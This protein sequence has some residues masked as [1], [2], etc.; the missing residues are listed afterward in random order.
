VRDGKPHG[1]EWQDDDLLGQRGVVYAR[2]W[3]GFPVYV[4]STQGTLRGRLK[5]H[6]RG[7]RAELGLC[8]W[9]WAE[10]KQMTIVAHKPDPISILGRDILVYRGL[11]A[12]LIVEFRPIPR[13]SR[14]WFV[15][16][17]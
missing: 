9:A 2:M 14:P 8:Y 12:A 15:G 16:R 10:G 5:T 4:G 3:E 13:K 17:I 11:E 1:I 7:T 6:L